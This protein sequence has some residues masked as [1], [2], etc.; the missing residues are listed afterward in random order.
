MCYNPDGK[1][2]IVG[3]LDGKCSFYDIIGI[4]LIIK[5]IINA[6]EFLLCKL[7]KLFAD[8]RMQLQI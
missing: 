5:E 7:L 6:C 4:S 2:S 3:T 1:G 8:D